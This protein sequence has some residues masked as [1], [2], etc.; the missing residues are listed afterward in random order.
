MFYIGIYIFEILVMEI[1]SDLNIK[2]IY[3]SV[4]YIGGLRIIVRDDIFFIICMCG[5]FVY[6]S[7]IMLIVFKYIC[8]CLK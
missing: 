8:F 3:I 1:K 6:F 7:I 4:K 5:Y 2:Y